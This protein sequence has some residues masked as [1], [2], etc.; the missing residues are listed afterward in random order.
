MATYAG[1]EGS[2]TFA[3]TAIGETTGWTLN[4]TVDLLDDTVLGDDWK[5]V[6]GGL[7]SWSGTA[8]GFI[9]YDNA[10]QAAAIVDIMASSPSGDSVALV[11]L[12]ATGKTFGGN[13][14]V[15]NIDF[16]LSKDGVAGFTMTFTGNGAL[17][18]SW[19]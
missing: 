18:P 9:D 5:T 7:G 12:V 13:A 6:I 4:A 11:F 14:L 19:A 2:V 16:D 17:T 10:Q 1:K 3:G 8:T 15:S